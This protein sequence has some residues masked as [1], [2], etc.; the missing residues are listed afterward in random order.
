M[1]SNQ[2]T[3]PTT[4]ADSTPAIQL[5]FGDMALRL[6]LM[7][8]EAVKVPNPKFN[9]EP[10]EA[11]D[12]TFKTIVTCEDFKSLVQ[13]LDGHKMNAKFISAK[14]ALEEQGAEE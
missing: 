11:F 8:T 12:L 1:E 3:A 7:H 6:V 4:T 14:E 5:I 2:A 10:I 13:L 9:K